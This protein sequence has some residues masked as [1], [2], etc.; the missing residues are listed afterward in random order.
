MD[1]DQQRSTLDGLVAASIGRADFARRHGLDTQAREAQ[2]SEVLARIEEGGIQVI[3]FCFVDSH[4]QLR[5]RPMEARHFAQA[6]RNGVPFTTALFAMDSAN[7]IF[8]PVFSA[9]GGFGRASM[10]GAGDMLAMAD[11]STFRILPWANK[12]ASVISD[13]YLTDGEPCPFDPRGV[14]RK[15]CGVLADQG[16]AFVGGVEVECHIFKVDDPRLGLEDCGQPPTPPAVSAYRH[17]YQY[18]SALVLD[19]YEP[20]ITPIRR[21]LIDLG[22]PLRTLECEWGPGQLEITL[23]P[24]LGVE[25]ADAVVMMRTAVKQVARRMGYLASFMTKPGLPNVYSCGWHL[26]ASLARMDGGGNAFVSAERPISDLGLHFVGGL[27]K[28]VRACTAFSNPTINGYKR[29]NANPLAPKR[30]VWS[31]DN[32]AA[33]CRLVGGAGDRSTHIENRS[34]EPL[35]NP[36][37]YMAS[38]IFAG[39]DGVSTAEDP[40]DPLT[41]P[42]GQTSKPLMPGSLMEA[43]EALA[44]CDMFRQTIGS[45]FIDHFVGMKRHEI[46]R[47]LSHVTDWEHREYFEA[48]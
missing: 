9:D 3:R 12:T 37:L 30:A 18:M 10:G 46:G 32:K 45:E 24:L 48:F 13:L 25:A 16:L 8:Q 11:L 40:G 7:T 23:D 14:M 43:I 22:L 36:Y 1:T 35:A 27:L 42:Y 34:G 44:A 20:I 6:A 19:D 15:A 5:A 4:G 17:G 26:H 21:A 33:L 29:L 41:D 28:H 31:I 2:L 39:M 47:F 38:Q